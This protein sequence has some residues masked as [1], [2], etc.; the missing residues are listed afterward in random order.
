M[1][2]NLNVGFLLLVLSTPLTANS[3]N[4]VVTINDITETKFKAVSETRSAMLYKLQAEK[5]QS[6]KNRHIF[7]D[8]LNKAKARDILNY[9][10]GQ[11]SFDNTTISFE[12]GF[13][14]KGALYLD[15]ASGLLGGNMINAPQLVI[16]LQSRQIK[17]KRI[18]I[19]KEDRIQTQI[20]FSCKFGI[21]FEPHTKE[22]CS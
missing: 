14:Y 1:K 20:N 6:K 2:F 18:I 4:G 5:Y 19:R 13:Y 8:G 11:F 10:H 3:F 16:N 7:L 21:A 17:A 15:K 9:R 12:H 22:A